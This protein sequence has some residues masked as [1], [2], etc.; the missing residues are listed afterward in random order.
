M[1]SDFMPTRSSIGCSLEKKPTPLQERI[2]RA[3][4][5]LARLIDDIGGGPALAGLRRDALRIKH[6]L[7]DVED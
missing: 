7:R 4:A 2:D 5:M 3:D 6:V 1:R